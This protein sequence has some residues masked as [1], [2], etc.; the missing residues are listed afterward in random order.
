M[1]HRP[2]LLQAFMQGVDEL[3]GHGLSNAYRQSDYSEEQERTLLAG[4]LERITQ[5]QGKP[6]A[7]GLA[8]WISE[9]RVTPDLLT[10]AGYAYT[11]NWCHDDQPKRLQTRSGQ[12]LWSIPTRRNSTT[13]PW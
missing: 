8:P 1:E 11:L 4:C 2:E 9:S 6:P 7:G 3:A 13:S 5:L 10:E 12:A